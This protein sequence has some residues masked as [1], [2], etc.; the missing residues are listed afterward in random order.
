MGILLQISLMRAAKSTCLTLLSFSS[1]L[2]II[3]IFDG[4][5]SICI[6]TYLVVRFGFGS[7]WPNAGSSCI[8]IGG[9]MLLIGVSNVVAIKIALK[10]SL[11]IT[12]LI[13]NI[14]G[15]V[16]AS[17]GGVIHIKLLW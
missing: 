4:L 5:I 13:A 15:L 1:I 12:S 3:H 10:R 2:G 6:G 11:V 14:L 8:W 9:Y 16:I 7:Y 17:L